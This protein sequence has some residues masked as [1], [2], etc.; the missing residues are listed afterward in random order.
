[1]WIFE[2]S[3]F[4]S[5]IL[6]LVSLKARGRVHAHSFSEELAN[7]A[8]FR[9]DLLTGK[10]GSAAR[11]QERSEIQSLILKS[12]LAG[13]FPSSAFEQMYTQ[14]MEEQENQRSRS[15]FGSLI[16]MRV[17]TIWFIGI[18][19]RLLCGLWMEHR[20]S[21]WEEALTL[22]FS[23]AILLAFYAILDRFYPKSWFWERCLTKEG[24]DWVRAHFLSVLP[25]DVSIYES[26]LALE[27]QERK[28]GCPLKEVKGLLLK[29]WSL[30]K[31]RN[32]ASQV[33][34]FEDFLPLWEFFI[35]GTCLTLLLGSRILTLIP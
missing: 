28:T 24:Q 33:R 26:W 9:I 19:S 3:I 11:A 16:F 31:N 13:E 12:Y 22:A 23:G 6:C 29:D 25:P 14:L 27:H 17:V 2:L 34:Q 8:K 32:Y 15:R 1:M 21:R 4:L 20:T 30:E 10:R 7:L 18:S 5:V 35:F